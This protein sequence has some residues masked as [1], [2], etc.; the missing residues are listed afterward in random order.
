MASCSTLPLCF[1]GRLP[2]NYVVLVDKTIDKK[3][4]ATEKSI[5]NLIPTTPSITQK[6]MAKH[7]NLSEIGIRYHIKK[8]KEKMLLK[9]TGGKKLGH[10]EI[11][12]RGH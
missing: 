11:I 8:L 12:T 6:E 1:S 5:I 4:S 3:L 2:C 9:R 7:L 10:W